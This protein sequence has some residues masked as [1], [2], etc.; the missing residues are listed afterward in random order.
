[1]IKAFTGEGRHL[2]AKRDNDNHQRLQTAG[3]FLFLQKSLILTYYFR[4]TQRH[5]PGKIPPQYL[6]K[7]TSLAVVSWRGRIP[8]AAG[9]ARPLWTMGSYLHRNGQNLFLASR[10]QLAAPPESSLL[11]CPFRP[12]GTKSLPVRVCRREETEKYLLLEGA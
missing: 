4:A 10:L 11:C 8:P 6:T 3:F 1:M 2:L 5:C 9:R 12:L 7:P